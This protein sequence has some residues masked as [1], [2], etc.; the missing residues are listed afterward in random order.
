MASISVSSASISNAMRYSQMRMQSDLVNAQKEMDTGQ[1]ADVGLA[2]GSNT[3][4]SVTF[5]R[6]IDRLNGIVDSNALVSSRLTSTQDALSQLTSAAQSLLA[7]MTTA[8]S[9]DMSGDLVANTGSSTL[10]SMTAVL[11]SSINGE[12]LFAGTNTDVKPISRTLP[13]PWRPTRPS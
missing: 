9:G 7:T 12:Y 13:P 10:S 11:N 8:V 5:S 1:V 4:Q 3:S 6:D 2:L